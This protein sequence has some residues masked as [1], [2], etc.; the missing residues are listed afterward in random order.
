MADWDEE[1]DRTFGAGQSAVASGSAAPANP[2]LERIRDAARDVDDIDIDELMA[3]AG[4]QAGVFDLG[5]SSAQRESPIQQLIRHWMNERHAPDILPIQ[6]QL[7][8]SILDHIRR[9]SEAVQLI[10][11]DPGA[12]QEEHFRIV[13]V[14]TEIERIKFIVRSYLRTRLFKI[15]K[16]ARYIVSNVDIQ[17]RISASERTYASKQARILDNHFWVTVLQSLP[18]AQSH[19]DDTPIFMPP[20]VTEPDKSR[21]VF[22]HALKQCP[23]VIL[24]DGSSLEMAKDHISLVPFSAVENLILREEVEL[25]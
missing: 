17:T 11:S 3:P 2:F 7:L 22:V 18:E 13:L 14:Q 8:A 25:V 10:R 23:P 19:L 21:A 5:D 20:M 12:S 16:Y 4:V 1:Y 24:P 15:E 9:Q 6:E